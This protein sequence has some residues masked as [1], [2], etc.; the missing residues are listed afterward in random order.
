VAFDLLLAIC[1]TTAFGSMIVMLPLLP[2]THGRSLA[3]LETAATDLALSFWTLLG[4]RS[5]SGGDQQDERK[6]CP[7]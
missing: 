3:T 2:K 1:S 6:F 7:P 4:R 5:E